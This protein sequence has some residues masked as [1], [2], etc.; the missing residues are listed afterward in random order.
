[1]RTNRPAIEAGALVS[2]RPGIMASS[3][4]G[5]S[6]DSRRVARGR[7]HRSRRTLGR[8]TDLQVRIEDLHVAGAAAATAGTSP[9]RIVRELRGKVGGANGVPGANVTETAPPFGS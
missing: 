6:P 7:Q 9:V 3:V 1:M 4:R 8:W 5:R 2:T